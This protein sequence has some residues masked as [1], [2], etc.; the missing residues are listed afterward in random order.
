MMAQESCANCRFSFGVQ[1]AWTGMV[2]CRRY[3]PEP[4]PSHSHGGPTASHIHVDASDWR[5]EYQEREH[6]T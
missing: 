1:D 5:G 6:T 3:P 2:R 4:G